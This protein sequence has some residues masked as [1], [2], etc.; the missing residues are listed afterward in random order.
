MAGQSTS[1]EPWRLAAAYDCGYDPQQHSLGNY[2][3]DPAPLAVQPRP[4]EAQALDLFASS[5]HGGLVEQ[6][7]THALAPFGLFSGDDRP[8][9]SNGHLGG[10][11]PVRLRPAWLVVVC[12]FTIVPSGPAHGGVAATGKAPLQSWATAAIYDDTATAHSIFT[13]SS[14]D[15]QVR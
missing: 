7:G 10:S 4:A 3:M 13:E 15:P 8:P 2:R 1:A 5:P 9:A 14:I 6:A 11:I 12:G